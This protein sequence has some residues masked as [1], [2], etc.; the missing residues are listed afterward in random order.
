MIGGL[1]S[2]QQTRLAGLLEILWTERSIRPSPGI[3][4][5][6]LVNPKHHWVSETAKLEDKIGGLATGQS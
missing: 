1:L 2:R 6:A 4:R 3:P 5:G